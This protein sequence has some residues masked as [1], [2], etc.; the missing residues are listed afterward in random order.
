[1][2]CDICGKESDDIQSFT[3]KNPD[4]SARLCR[5][6]Y[7]LVAKNNR[8]T[9]K[10]VAKKCMACHQPIGYEWVA[11]KAPGRKRKGAKNSQGLDAFFDMRTS[12]ERA[13]GV[14]ARKKRGEEKGASQHL[15]NLPAEEGQGVQP[16]VQADAPPS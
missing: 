11:Y 15:D 5:E 1:M 3:L 14:K 2:K 7:D 10:L 9:G 8:V 4:E 12:V 16:D 13:L 6:H